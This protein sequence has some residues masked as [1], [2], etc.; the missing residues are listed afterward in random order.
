MTAEED[1]PNYV[2]AAIPVRGCPT[3][4]QVRPGGGECPTP[5]SAMCR[6]AAGSWC[7]SCPVMAHKAAHRAAR[8]RR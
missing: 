3:C 6:V 4:A 8:A 1:A 2:L 5:A 7:A